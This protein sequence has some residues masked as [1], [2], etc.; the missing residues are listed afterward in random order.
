MMTFLQIVIVLLIIA[1][2]AMILGYMFGQF[3]CKKLA[4]SHYVEKGK[5]CETE[6]AQ[7]HGLNEQIDHLELE[8]LE[9]A[10][11]KNRNDNETTQNEDNK[12]SKELLEREDTKEES[13]NEVK[14][15]L[16]GNEK[17]NDRKEDI[18]NEDDKEELKD[19][20]REYKLS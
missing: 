3:S 2:I 18:Q 10:H 7:K 4:K 6:Y 1:L 20:R 15:S 16:I 9:E 14:E 19:E 5:Y 17:A 8:M 13:V 12:D 11:N